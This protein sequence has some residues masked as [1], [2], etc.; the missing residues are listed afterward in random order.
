MTEP[1]K[2]PENMREP[3]DFRMHNR[4]KVVYSFH[5]CC[6]CGIVHQAPFGFKGKW[7]CKEHLPQN[8]KTMKS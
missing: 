1:I 8:Y 5:P 3:D 2:A 7:Y 4:H 6:V